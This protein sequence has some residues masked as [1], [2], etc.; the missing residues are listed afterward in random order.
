M[1]HP[2]KTRGKFGKALFWG[3][4]TFGAS[5]LAFFPW[6]Q[7]PQMPAPTPAAA[8]LDVAPTLTPKH[9]R[10]ASQPDSEPNS[11]AS[12]LGN[13]E[14]SLPAANRGGFFGLEVQS[15]NG[16]K[17]SARE[18][19]LRLRRGLASLPEDTA[20]SSLQ[21][22]A[23]I[24]RQDWNSLFLS[25]TGQI[26]YACMQMASG[27]DASCPIYENPIYPEGPV[28]DQIPLLESKPDAEFLVY[29]NFAGG[30]V[31]SDAIPQV[32]YEVLPYT[33]NPDFSTF[34]ENELDVI[35][36]TWKIVSEIFSPFDINV[37]TKRLPER[38]S[39]KKY[40]SVSITGTYDKNGLVTPPGKTNV[41]GLAYRGVVFL[42]E[43][44]AE[45]HKPAWVVG[46]GDA[47]PRSIAG[48]I[49]HELGHNFGLMH[50]GYESGGT[51]HEYFPSVIFPRKTWS[52][53]P[54]SDYHFWTSIMGSSSVS[55][56]FIQWSK[57][58]YFGANQHQDDVDIIAY[59]AGFDQ[60]DLDLPKNNGTYLLGELSGTRSVDGLFKNQLE[61]RFTVT[62]TQNR[63]A[64]SAK[65]TVFPEGKTLAG[66]AVGP[67]MLD[68]STELKEISSVAALP[69][70]ELWPVIFLGHSGVFE[71]T[72]GST[73]EI[74][75][76][77]QGRGNPLA[78]NDLF[79]QIG[80][81]LP[82][83]GYTAYGSLGTYQL[84]VHSYESS[85]PIGNEPRELFSSYYGASEDMDIRMK[86]NLKKKV[87]S[88][89][90]Q[91][92]GV[93]MKWRGL[94]DENGHS[95]SLNHP[96][97]GPVQITMTVL[98][99]EGVLILVDFDLLVS[100][101]DWDGTGL[102]FDRVSKSFEVT[103]RPITRLA[104]KK[105]IKTVGFWQDENSNPS[106]A[107]PTRITV[108]PNSRTTLAAVLPNGKRITA[109]G[110]AYNNQAPFF[111]TLAPIKSNTF[112]TKPWS[113][114][115]IRGEISFIPDEAP[116]FTGEMRW[117][118]TPYSALTMERETPTTLDFVP[119]D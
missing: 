23:D 4:L 116:I 39:N 42:E 110:W 60:T 91:L 2:A 53:G 102:P 74:T 18:L 92:A 94:F 65:P 5:A 33:L 96:A 56:G 73:Y 97:V 113:K 84:L 63:L 82:F 12:H 93:K 46:Q 68:F 89:Q 3:S 10:N 77:P 61:H 111:R 64:I 76:R 45:M 24:P 55:Y 119:V 25:P 83:S 103:A 72:P 13:G 28:D 106:G 66:D 114:S 31:V 22:I 108:R 101:L 70:E 37:S 50:D 62:P 41:K 98:G 71:V 107:K 75:L 36:R 87:F 38:Y 30:Q 117:N 11:V 40:L 81:F 43:S 6:H 90:L 99:A 26:G 48:T 59:T 17:I 58:E 19:P 34:D 95:L 9:P 47:S 51:F 79:L 32:T 85:E 88:A 49:C 1:N 57:G 112:A 29:L 15:K 44:L 20:L 52:G 16:Q 14:G 78:R 105:I 80:S 27:E 115:S 8:F 86:V 7:S 21:G 100:K 104:S 54:I 69:L 67:A 109:A 118:P 35:F